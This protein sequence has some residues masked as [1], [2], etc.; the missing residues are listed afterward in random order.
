MCEIDCGGSSGKPGQPS[1][2]PWN[3][4][5]DCGSWFA[6][7][8][9]DYRRDFLAYAR[10]W[11]LERKEDAW[12]QMPTRLNLADLVDGVKMWHGNTRSPSCPEGF[13]EEEAIKAIWDQEARSMQKKPGQ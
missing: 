11:L 6:H 9:A 13:N 10:R 4:G 8:S 7:Q 1:T 3:W 2:F 12:L 5:Y